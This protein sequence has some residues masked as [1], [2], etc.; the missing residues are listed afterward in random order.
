ME[1]KMGVL[2]SFQPDEQLK[3]SG[4]L[5]NHWK[6]TFLGLKQ[7]SEPLKQTGPQ[8]PI[9]IFVMA[10]LPEGNWTGSK[11]LATAEHGLRLGS[12]PRSL[13]GV[14]KM[15]MHCSY[16]KLPDILCAWFCWDCWM[17]YCRE[18]KTDEKS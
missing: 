14:S 7:K 2:D 10:D 17:N 13:N 15:K 6:A 5:K 8:Q 11:K 9:H 12:L 4:Q 16:Q 1:K 18:Y 3:L